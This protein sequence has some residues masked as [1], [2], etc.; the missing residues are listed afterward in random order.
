MTFSLNEET[1]CISS[2][3][4]TWEISYCS[5]GGIWGTEAGSYLRVRIPRPSSLWT[6]ETER[7]E[8]GIRAA[9]Y[10]TASCTKSLKLLGAPIS[11]VSRPLRTRAGVSLPRPRSHMLYSFSWSPHH[12]S[13]HSR[14]SKSHLLHFSSPGLSAPA[15]T[16]SRLARSRLLLPCSLEVEYSL[17]DSSRAL[18]QNEHRGWLTLAR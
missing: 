6:M 11:M 12:L 17:A 15:H 8:R 7:H 14:Y 9:E 16:P 5:S 2:D 4:C 13:T 10:H 1:R 3:R 18:S